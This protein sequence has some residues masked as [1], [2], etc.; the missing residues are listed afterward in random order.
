MTPEQLPPPK[1]VE[2]QALKGQE[3][4]LRKQAEAMIKHAC[5]LEQEAE[6]ILSV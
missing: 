1:F 4:T 2:Y 5:R 6:S 3:E